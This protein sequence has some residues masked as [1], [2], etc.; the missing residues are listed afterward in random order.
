MYYKD[1]VI[2]MS[3]CKICQLL[4]KILPRKR[5]FL[6][7]LNI[8]DTLS[9]NKSQWNNKVHDFLNNNDKQN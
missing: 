1:I 3:Y 5:D 9:T 7:S 8:N 4:M 2:D 6:D